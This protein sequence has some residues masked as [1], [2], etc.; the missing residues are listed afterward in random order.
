MPTNHTDVDQF[1]TVV[2]FN[3]G[4]AAT[5]ASVR[6]AIEPLADRGH[7][8]RRRLLSG[9]VGDVV[10]CR[11]AP[12]FNDQAKWVASL[13]PVGHSQ[14]DVASAFYIVFELE[15]PKNCVLKEIHATLLGSAGHAGLPAT[16]PR[17]RLL[18]QDTGSSGAPTA[19]GDQSDTSASVGAYEVPHSVSIAGLSEVIA[20][21]GG[22]RYYVRIDGEAG[23]NSQAALAIL[24]VTAVV[25]PS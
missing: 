5:A 24:D 20:H 11:F 16:M 17:L 6:A 21:D 23:A 3:D 22:N 10:Q 7:F 13:S 2:K 19:L 12:T 1:N 15:L 14:S 18:R 8:L 25:D 9:E 4:E